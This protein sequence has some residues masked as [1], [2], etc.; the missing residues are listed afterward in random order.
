VRCS[1]LTHEV[2]V[3]LI[4]SL[5]VFET[6]S[7]VNFSEVSVLM[8]SLGN[9][10]WSYKQSMEMQTEHGAANRVW[11]CKQSMELQTVYGAANRLWS[12]KQGMELLT[13]YGAANRVRSCKQSK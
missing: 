4:Y 10:V 3:G 11:R 7:S 12:C 13:E 2:N 1:T 5:Q 6:E 9:R 8:L